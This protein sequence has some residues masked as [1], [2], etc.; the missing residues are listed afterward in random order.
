[1]AT[2]KCKAETIKACSEGA[3]EYGFH[4]TD[5]QPSGVPSHHNYSKSLGTLPSS[6]QGFNPAQFSS[7]PA[8]NL[9]MQGK[10]L[11][12]LQMLWQQLSLANS[13]LSTQHLTT[14]S[15]VQPRSYDK[16]GYSV[17]ISNGILC[18]SNEE[19]GIVMMK[20]G[21]QFHISI[22]NDNDFGELNAHVDIINLFS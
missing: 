14:D 19:R 21:T 5:P 13:G 15:T 10:Q 20:T 11:E 17:L 6:F 18:D 3:M 16:G 4:S 1:M 8:N 12:I 22:A 2:S 9:A 7:G